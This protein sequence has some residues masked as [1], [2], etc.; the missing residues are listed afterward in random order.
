MKLINIYIVKEF[1]FFKRF[2]YWRVCCFACTREPKKS[3]HQRRNTVVSRPST[4]Y[5]S[6]R[7]TLTSNVRRSVRN[8]QRSA[9]SGID[10]YYDT[11]LNHAHSDTDLRYDYLAENSQFQNFSPRNGKARDRNRY[12]TN[13]QDRHRPR[14]RYQD[15][16]FDRHTV[17]RERQFPRLSINRARDDSELY[18]NRSR[19]PYGSVRSP[20]ER[21]VGPPDRE[22]NRLS[23]NSKYSDIYPAG[24]CASVPR[25]PG[26]RAQ[27]LDPKSRTDPF[28]VHVNK[29]ELRKT[30][31]LCNK[32]AFEIIDD[33]KSK[34][35]PYNRSQ[36]LPRPHPQ[37][38]RDFLEPPGGPMQYYD[39]DDDIEMQS[40]PTRV[41]RSRKKERP[42]PTSS[43]RIMSPM[44]MMVPRQARH[45]AQLRDN[46][47]FDEDWDS[48]HDLPPKS[49][50][51]PIWLCVC[52][53][54][55]YILAGAYIFSK[56]EKWSFLDSA[57]FCFVTLT[58]IGMNNFK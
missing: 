14:D 38:R 43:P 26:A 5:P 36:S 37:R 55:G 19:R 24:R 52:L 6:T 7:S 48:V 2:L 31:V 35:I 53:V 13:P 42:D 39:M 11:T 9:D 15:R 30:P 27:S 18:E 33:P 23:R 34:R 4:R 17:E 45:L 22:L 20:R 57:Y 49:R 3:R 51:V 16:Q 56:W 8:S 1:I 32:Y 44:G 12:D 21:D 54:V 25:S 58:T 47:S 10:P 29:E 28:D 50:P 40:P 46:D 41:H